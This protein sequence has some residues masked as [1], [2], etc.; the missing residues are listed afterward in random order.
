MQGFSD[1]S[2]IMFLVVEFGR[3]RRSTSNA[4]AMSHC[5]TID[6]H[7]PFPQP[8][9]ETTSQM[10]EQQGLASM[11]SSRVLRFAEHDESEQAEI[12][13]ALLMQH[14]ALANELRML[15]HSLTG[16]VARRTYL[17]LFMCT[18]YDILQLV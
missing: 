7:A 10:N 2:I 9:S 6:Q 13:M 5:S 8:D 16:R 18:L 14:S 1:L 17:A 12:R 11:G 3:T 4:S 15:F